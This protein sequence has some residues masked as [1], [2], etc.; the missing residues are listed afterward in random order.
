MVCNQNIFDFAG[1]WG[2]HANWNK[3][4]REGQMPHDLSYM[5]N[6]K[7]PAHRNRTDTW[8]PEV[9]G[10]ERGKWVKLG[11]RYTASSY[12]SWWYNVQH[13]DW[14]W[15]YCI[16]YL[17][18]AMRGASLVAQMVENLPAMPETRFNSRVG[19]IP[20]EGHANRLQ[21]SCLENPMDRGAWRAK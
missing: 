17:K 3:S 16:I 2:Y 15:K 10:Q 5:W 1:P 13:D 12:K 20:G 11:K 4:D 14:S 8:L 21:Y 6:L 9:G 19:K 7:N 18:V